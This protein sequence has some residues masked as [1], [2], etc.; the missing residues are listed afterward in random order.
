MPNTTGHCPTKKKMYKKED[1]IS[2][3]LLTNLIPLFS[4]I[5]L[6]EATVNHCLEQSLE[7]HK[8]KSIQTYPIFSRQRCAGTVGALPILARSQL[9]IDLQKSLRERGGLRRAVRMKGSGL[10]L[11]KR[12]YKI[13]S[14][15]ATRTNLILSFS[16]THAERRMMST[17]S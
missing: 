8:V 6:A 4:L 5:S 11:A 15:R 16:L 17:D 7:T 13:T 1:V 2:S 14:S 3:Q 10:N 12:G 9:D